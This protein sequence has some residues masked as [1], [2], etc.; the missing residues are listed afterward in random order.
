[1]HGDLSVW[2]LRE[3][4]GGG[5]VPTLVDWEYAGWGPPGAD[6]TWYRASAAA[7]TGV[8]S[9]A[10]ADEE[11]ALYWERWVR[12]WYAAGQKD[13][14]DRALLLDALGRMRVRASGVG[15]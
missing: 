5:P 15:Q 7:V 3:C 9:P 8:L 13:R 11:A 2:N 14:R 6:W 4:V 12:S 1:M 10:P